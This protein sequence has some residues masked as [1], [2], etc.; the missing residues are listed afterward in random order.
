MFVLDC[1]EGFV[2][3]RDTAMF[4][5]FKD[6]S[7]SCLVDEILY[8]AITLCSNQKYLMIIYL[9]VDWKSL[10]IIYDSTRQLLMVNNDLSYFSVNLWCKVFIVQP[11]SMSQAVY[12]KN[13]NLLKWP[14]VQSWAKMNFSS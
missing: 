3:H 12:A 9:P 4:T 13:K 2:A 11:I 6:K 14:N 5:F 8:Q 10:I 1:N 7:W